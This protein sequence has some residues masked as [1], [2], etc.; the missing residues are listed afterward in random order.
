MGGVIVQNDVGM[1]WLKGISRSIRL[2]NSSRP[3]HHAITGH[4]GGNVVAKH[5]CTLISL[6]LGATYIPVLSE[7]GK[8]FGGLHRD[9]RLPFEVLDLDFPT[10]L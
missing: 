8:A 1:C 2:R 10:K 3:I 7:I 6:S 9:S 4:P 5:S